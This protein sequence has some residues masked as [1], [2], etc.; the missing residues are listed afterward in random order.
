M[1]IVIELSDKDA[2]FLL[3]SSFIPVGYFKTVHKALHNGTPL[4]KGHGDL[5]D[6]QALYNGPHFLMTG[7]A[8]VDDKDFGEQTFDMFLRQDIESQEAIIPAD[9]GDSE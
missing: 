9:K 1:Q 7:N 8:K 2:E 6:R 4:P 5:I 3:N